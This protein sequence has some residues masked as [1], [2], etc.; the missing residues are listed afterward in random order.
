MANL[1]VQRNDGVVRLT[2]NRP[3]RLNAVT[4]EMWDELTDVFGEV[5][6][7]DDDRV[8]VITGAGKGF[9]SGADLGAGG[10][11][12]QGGPLDLMRRV[13]MCATT[14]HRMPKPTIA[15]V[16][17][18]AVGAGCNLAL[19]CDLVIASEE[20]R[21]SE[22]FVRRALSID[23]AG[24]YLLPRL[25]GMRKAK[26]LALLAEMIPADE[27]ERIGLVNRVVPADQLEAAV[28]DVVERLL[29]MA[30]LALAQTKAL[31][32]RGLSRSIEDA[33]EAEGAA[34]AVNRKTADSAEALAAFVEKRDPKFTGR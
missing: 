9:C 12:E 8:L 19:S 23:F 11:S 18:A 16:N 27:A 10:S 34:Q 4:P 29:H 21:F 26:E 33:V 30:P 22:I 7:R 32:D 20:A 2:L 6:A 14:L 3:E 1:L 25:V 28:T 31:L 13:G 5:A 17:G 24:S 15:A